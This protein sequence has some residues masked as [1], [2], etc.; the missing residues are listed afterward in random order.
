MAVINQTQIRYSEYDM[1]ASVAS[2]ALKDVYGFKKC[3]ERWGALI[4][5]SLILYVNDCTGFAKQNQLEVN[6]VIGKLSENLTA[7]CC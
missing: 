6:C 2:I 1:S 7:N 4:A 5:K 3:N